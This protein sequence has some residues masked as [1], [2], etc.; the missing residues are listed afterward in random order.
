VARPGAPAVDDAFGV[1][2]HPLRRQLLER[3]A[4]GESR[5]TELAARLPVSRPAVSQHLRLMLDVGIVEERRQG[6]ER[7]YSLRRDR[8]GDVD[9]WLERLD[10]FWDVGLDRLGRHLA[11]TPMETQHHET[12]S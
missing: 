8:L 12:R 7:Y 10:A 2:S 9:R 5:V 3:L 1:I 4:G 6:R 11:T